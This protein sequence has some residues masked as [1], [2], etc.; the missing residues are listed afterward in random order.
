MKGLTVRR[1][2]SFNEALNCFLMGSPL[3][4]VSSHLLNS[5]SSRS[6]TVF[7]VM[8]EAKDAMQ[9]QQTIKTSKIHLVDLAGCE[10][11]KKTNSEGAVLKESSFINKSLSFLEMVIQ[12]HIQIHI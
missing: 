1:C 7:S 12:T 5:H 4:V 9:M 10:R 2:E 8:V 6:H 3:R 11:V